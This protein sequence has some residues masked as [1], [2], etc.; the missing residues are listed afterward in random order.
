MEKMHCETPTVRTPR[1]LGAA[2]VL[3]DRRPAWPWGVPAQGQAVTGTGRSR[4]VGQ[5]PPCVGG[6]SRVTEPGPAPRLDADPP[7]PAAFLLGDPRNYCFPSELDPS[8][9]KH[10]DVKITLNR[11]VSAHGLPQRG[12][13]NRQHERSL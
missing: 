11:S 13:A 2:L 5:A 3:G 10:N 7:R 8:K 6:V 1:A 12:L 4:S 9:K